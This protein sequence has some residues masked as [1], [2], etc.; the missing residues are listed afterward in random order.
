MRMRQAERHE[1]HIQTAHYIHREKQIFPSSKEWGGG[2][3]RWGG[4]NQ[5]FL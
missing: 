1:I 3:G 4:D 5:R 2:V